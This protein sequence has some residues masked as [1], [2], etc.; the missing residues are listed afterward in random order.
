MGQETDPA[1]KCPIC[2]EEIDT[3]NL[4]GVDDQTIDGPYT[5]HN[6][7]RCEC[8]IKKIYCTECLYGWYQHGNVICPICRKGDRPVSRHE[9]VHNY[10]NIFSHDQEHLN[11]FS[12]GS[13][14]MVSL[15]FIELMAISAGGEEIINMVKTITV[16]ACI[17][18]MV[19]GL[20]LFVLLID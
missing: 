4:H 3:S 7:D 8:K 16:F 17:G 14:T 19:F 9:Y 13:S 15:D 18:T 2:L 20:S 11:E 10:E 6:D 1:I 12:I 5:Q